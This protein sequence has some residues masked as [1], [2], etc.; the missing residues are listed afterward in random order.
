MFRP[1]LRPT[2]DMSTQEHTQEDYN[3]NQRGHFL[4]FCVDMPKDG[5]I[6]D[7]N[8][9]HRREGNLNR[10]Y[11]LVFCSTEENVVSVILLSTPLHAFSPHKY[12]IF[13]K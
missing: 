12:K 6:T 11:M 8:M 5:L 2:S 10:L 1:V 4:Y 13:S 3:R 7:R 9:Y